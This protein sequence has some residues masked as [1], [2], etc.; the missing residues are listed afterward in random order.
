MLA[1]AIEDVATLQY[2]LMATP[3]LDGI[4]CVIVNGQPLTRK[5]KPIPNKHVAAMLKTLPDG[6]DGELMCF[7]KTFNETQSL[8]MSEEGTPDFTYCVFDYIKDDTYVGRINVLRHLTL[9]NW[10]KLVL[11]ITVDN[12]QQ[13]LAL[14]EKILA[15][16]YEGV[17]LRAPSGPYKFGRS[18][19]KEGYLLK[20][21]RFKD[22]EAEIVGFEEK[23]KNNNLATKDELGYTKRS[24]HKANKV[25]TG[26]LGKLIV[27]DINS[28]VLF[29]I[30]TGFDDKLRKLIWKNKK[31]YKGKIVN[32][33]YQDIGMKDKPRFPSF[34]GFRHD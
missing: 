13:L 22:S 23:M 15:A 31:K 17:M 20:L 9:P 28:G 19:L 6:L 30:G 33:V 1:V 18:T 26:T 5:L 12:E 14:E 21:K 4:R 24:S 2:P 8:L 10:V 7:G 32:Y 11:P 27:Q 25:P 16:S 3:K 34:R 29:S